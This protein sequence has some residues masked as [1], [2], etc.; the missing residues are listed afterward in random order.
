VPL[1]QKLPLHHAAGS[2]ISSVEELKQIIV[3]MRQSSGVLSFGGLIPSLTYL[4][5]IA[6]VSTGIEPRDGI[7]RYNGRD[8]VL[9]QVNK[10]SGANV[11]RV[12]ERVKDTLGKIEAEHPDLEF[13][14]ITD[15]SLFINQSIGNLA[16]SGI[17]GG[18]LAVAV[19][20]IS[21]AASAAYL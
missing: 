13:S 18:F 14:V 10:Q 1:Q 21:S 19:L 9:V 2:Q 11:V 4:G 5:D 7:T 12:A 20:W 3:G 8:A 16:S 17:V 6:E 15:Q